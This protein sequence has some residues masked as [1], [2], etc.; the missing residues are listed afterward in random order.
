[1][2][3][4]KLPRIE[5]A[6]VV[7]GGGLLLIGLAR[8]ISRGEPAAARWP[9]Y[10]MLLLLAAVAGNLF[11]RSRALGAIVAAVGGLLLLAAVVAALFPAE[12]GGSHPAGAA[13]R[14]VVALGCL[15]AAGLLQLRGPGQ[16]RPASPVSGQR[17]EGK[18]LD[19]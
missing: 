17:T 2:S 13:V 10:V 12:G 4:R 6:L 15:V 7:I 11:V 9:T 19:G 8:A 5:I 14:A 1:M 18:H 16:P 3:L